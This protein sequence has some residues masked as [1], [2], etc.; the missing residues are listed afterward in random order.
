LLH[1]RSRAVTFFDWV[2]WV[3]L[4]FGTGGLILAVLG[5]TAIRTHGETAVAILALVLVLSLTSFASPLF[6]YGS[7]LR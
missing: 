3:A 2:A 1:K 4:G 6:L 5:I 7:L